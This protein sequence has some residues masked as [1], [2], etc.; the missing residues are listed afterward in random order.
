MEQ[1]T[2]LL[3]ALSTV[4]TKA[5]VVRQVP[6]VNINQSTKAEAAA[7]FAMIDVE[8]D[9]KEIPLELSS[10]EDS[11][12][13]EEFSM[14][15][16]IEPVPDG[17]YSTGTRLDI[18]LYNVN[19]LSCTS[20]NPNGEKTYSTCHYTKGNPFCP[21]KDIKLAFVGEQ[22]IFAERINRAK[23]N[24]DGDRVFQL[25]IK[26]QD[27]DADFRNAVLQKVGLIT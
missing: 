3:A 16:C 19:C 14:P 13:E 1:N 25:L 15:D 12:E 10:E 20:L 27:K 8:E 18:K 2:T 9:E 23:T 11:P 22:S 7:A 6:H 4:P 24:K 5:A 21:A 26:L 17:S